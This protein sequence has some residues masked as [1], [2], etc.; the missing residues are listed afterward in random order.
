GQLVR[1]RDPEV[2][3][4]LQLTPEQ[5]EQVARLSETWAE[6]GLMQFRGP[7]GGFPPEALGQKFL[8]VARANEKKLNDILTPEQRK[9]FP[10]VVIQLQGP[11]AFHDSPVVDELRLTAD[12]RRQIREL[13]DKAM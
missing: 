12:Q 13:K 3:R 8:E 9:R 6:Q 4:A 7:R 5:R 11:I 1:I 10:Q 2:Q